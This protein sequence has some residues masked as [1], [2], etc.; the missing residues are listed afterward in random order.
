MKKCYI[1][2]SN[3][4]MTDSTK[5]TKVLIVEDEPSIALDISGIL[6]DDGYD[7]V[8]VARSGPK[9]LDMLA[10]RSPDIALLDISIEGQQ[11]GI[12]I[13]HIIKDKYKIPYV[14]LTSHSD[15]E[16][17][18]EVT[19]TAPYGYIVKPFK[20]TDLAPAIEI[21]LIR[22]SEVEQKIPTL[23]EINDQLIN[24]VTKKE[25]ETLLLIYQGLSNKEMTEKAHLS[26]NTIKSHISSLYS[27][28]EVN[29]RS[30][31]LAKIREI[32]SS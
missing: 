1:S 16:T 13:A 30:A 25:Y 11:T 6:K 12:D 27:K 4:G 19:K 21:A 15:R 3:C 20:D 28:L 8:G 10:T 22:Y 5:K 23:D 24:H 9:A 31:L 17:V 7:I 29:N 18:K 26:V 2:V 32:A 14:F